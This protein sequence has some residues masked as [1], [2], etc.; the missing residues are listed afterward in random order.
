[1]SPARIARAAAA[2]AD[3][4]AESP[5]ESRLRLLLARAGLPA[6]PQFVVR[7]ADGRFVARVDLAYPE[8][9]LAVEYDGAWHA[10]DGQFA[11][12]RQRLNRLVAAGWVVLH[13]TAADL[14]RPDQLVARVR[15]LR[16]ARG[17]GS[18]AADA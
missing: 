15:A 14:R 9:C 13:V 7:D 5:P 8:L 18:G 3:P 12:D 17:R 1:M 10:E 11:R 6:V 2:F 16:A 4:R